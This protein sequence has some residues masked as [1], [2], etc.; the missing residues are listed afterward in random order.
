MHYQSWR[1]VLTALAVPSV[2]AG[3]VS[4]GYTG[5][6]FDS[7]DGRLRARIAVAVSDRYAWGECSPQIVNLWLHRSDRAL[8][9]ERRLGI[10]GC[11]VRWTVRWIGSDAA[12]FEVFDYGPAHW[13]TT[14]DRVPPVQERRVLA[15]ET[16]RAPAV[17]TAK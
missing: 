12:V 2:L 16:L 5:Q 6:T 10:T 4:Y 17:S 8:A 9:A 1:T 3:C 14:A 11:D 7:E 13:G 15:V